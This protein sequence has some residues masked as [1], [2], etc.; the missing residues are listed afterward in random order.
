MMSE[1]ECTG[2]KIIREEN[3]QVCSESRTDLGID[4]LLRAPDD[5]RDDITL[6]LTFID[7]MPPVT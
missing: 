7:V 1:D 5:G 4:V 3:T 6:G 2:T